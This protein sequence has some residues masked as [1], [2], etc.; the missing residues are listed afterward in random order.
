MMFGKNK[1]TFTN[2]L[3]VKRTGK[4]CNNTQNFPLPK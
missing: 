2:N 3:Q 4:F 1:K